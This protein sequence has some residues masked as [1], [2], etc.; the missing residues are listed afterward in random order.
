M[1]LALYIQNGQT[2][3][4]PVLEGDTSWELSRNGQ[5]GKLSFSVLADGRLNIE[6]G[7]A[8]RLDVDGK[9]V[10]FGFL[11]ERSCGSDGRMKLTAYD[12]LRYLKN[13]D[14][15]NYTELTASELIA[16]IAGDYQL[17]VGVLEDTGHKIKFR[18]ERD[19]TLFD[20]ILTALDLTMTATK[21][22][23][24]LY[25][26]VGKLTL[27]NISNMMLNLMIDKTT[28]QDYEFKSSID[29]NTYNQINLYY[30]NSETKK[31][32]VY[33]VKD[34]ANINKWGIL[35]MRESIK[36]GENGQLAAETYLSLYNRP[37]K[38]LQ[39]KGAFGDVKVRAGCL[40][41]TFLTAGDLV[42]KNYMQVEAVTHKFS[43]GIHLMDL[44]LR[45]GAINA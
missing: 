31:Q 16:K 4:C 10:F 2:V 42:L 6:E 34:S 40:I 43:Q 15:Y 11:F 5:P 37:T 14:S 3:F 13:T 26:D 7:N 21:N 33:L 45:G 36:E 44:T 17:Q 28:A 39:I 18:K 27:K 35:Q 25:D 29:S 19:K 23:F 41:P 8:I 38:S 24:V 32:E 1:E 12:Q 30:D 20:I 9:P 22:M